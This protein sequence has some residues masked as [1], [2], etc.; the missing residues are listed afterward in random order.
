MTADVS[1]WGVVEIMG[2]RTRAG[3]LSDAQLGGATL[4]RIEHP[5]RTDHTGESPLAEFYA[6]SAIFDIR[7]C[8]PEEAEKVAAWAWPGAMPARPALSSGFEDLVDGEDDEDD[9]DNVCGCPCVGVH[10]P[11]CDLYDPVEP[12]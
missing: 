6:P 3:R 9:D 4:L 1:M 2:H 11:S 8:S 5:S 10:D 7:L 12:F